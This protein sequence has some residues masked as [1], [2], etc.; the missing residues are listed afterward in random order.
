MAGGGQGTSVV[1]AVAGVRSPG[2][3][4]SACCKKKKKKKKKA[5]TESSS[6]VIQYKRSGNC[7]RLKRHDN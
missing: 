5:L 3:R 2:P 6:H 7:S 1:A 4:T